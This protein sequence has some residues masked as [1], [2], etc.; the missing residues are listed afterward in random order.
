MLFDLGNQGSVDIQP[1]GIKYINLEIHFSKVSRYKSLINGLFSHF[2]PRT[3]LVRVNPNALKQ[4]FIQVFCN[5]LYNIILQLNIFVLLLL[6]CEI[7]RSYWMNWKTRKNMACKGAIS[8]KILRSSNQLRDKAFI[9]MVIAPF[10]RYLFFL[11][12]SL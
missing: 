7:C 1:L 6:S 12:F 11:S 8:W 9:P 4:N 10:Y 3:L 5:G 2:H